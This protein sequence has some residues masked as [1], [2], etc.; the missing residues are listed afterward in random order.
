MNKYNTLITREE[1]IR[2]LTIKM[3][4]THRNPPILRGKSAPRDAR[5]KDAFRKAFA[6]WFVEE[7]IEKNGLVVMNTYAPPTLGHGLH[8]KEQSATPPQR[9]A[10]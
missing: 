2:R 7:C 3:A 5:E 10:Q 4:A 6:T 9:F 8:V 1:L